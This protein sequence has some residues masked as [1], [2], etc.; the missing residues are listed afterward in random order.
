MN[1]YLVFKSLHLVSMVAWFAGIF[2]LVRLFVYHTE[3]EDR[4][5]TEAKVL[6]AQYEIMEDRLFKIIVR[7]AMVLTWVFGLLLI[8]ELGLDWL[9]GTPWI[10]LK[11]L[12]VFLL[13]GYSDYLGRIT[14]QL[15]LGKVVMSSYQFR[16][17]NEIPTLFLLSIILLAVF[18]DLANFG[19]TFLVIL[20]AAIL[21]FVGT[22]WYRKVRL[23]NKKKNYEEV[24]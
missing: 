23:A 10:H 18:K 1:S 16:L 12:L 15:R 5:A 13:S 19:L 20:G 3:A 17:F 6:K 4:P 21:L 14:K 9:K 22:R 2:Y 24:T 7:P 11:L 8:H